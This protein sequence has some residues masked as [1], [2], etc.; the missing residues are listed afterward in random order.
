MED[1][2]RGGGARGA[3]ARARRR[4]IPSRWTPSS[5]GSTATATGA[6][7]RSSAPRSGRSR[8][9]CST[10]RAR[11]SACRS[12]SCSAGKF[13]DRVACYANHWFFGAQT[14]EEYAATP[15]AAVAMGYRALKWDPFDVADL[16]MD[17]QQRRQTIEIVEAVRDAVGPDVELMLD[18]H[19]R[20]NVPTAIAMCRAL[21][22]L[23]PDLDRGA[24]AAR[25][26]RGPR[27]SP[28]RE[29]GADR[30]RRALVR[31]RPVPRGA[32]TE[33]PSTSCS[34]TSPMPAASAR[35]SGS[36]IW[37]MP[38][39]PGRAAQP[40]RAG[41]ERDDTASRGR[42]PELHGLRD[43]LDRRPLAQGAG[44]R[45]AAFEDGAILAPPRPASASS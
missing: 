26:H 9:R 7:A 24:D 38:P 20:L 33:R 37:R 5:S 31:A 35:P 28:R 14:P 18:V 43:G 42:D 15:R 1:E 13:R 21:A 19:G 30:R 23:R 3:G 36:R 41:D 8:R 32:A 45:D 25:E 2:D 10:S 11:R 29:P 44:A 34:P 39:D 40:G 6:P 4:A 22:R 27:R 16:E 12:S 17:R